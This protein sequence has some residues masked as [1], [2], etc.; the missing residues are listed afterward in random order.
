[1]KTLTHTNWV[2][3]ALFFITLPLYGCAS[4]KQNEVNPITSESAVVASPHVFE[5]DGGTKRAS[6][7][8]LMALF[9]KTAYRTDI[10]DKK[11]RR[12]TACDYLTHPEHRDVLLGM[13]RDAAGSGWA[14]WTPPGSCYGEDGLYFETYVHSNEKGDIDKAVIGIRGTENNSVYEFR[15]D[16]EANLSGMTHAEN[17]EYDLAARHI[18]PVINQLAKLRLN[19]NP[20][21]IYLTGHSLGGGIAQYIAYLAPEVTATFTFDTSPVT[22]W[23]QLP[24]DKKTRTPKIYR[25]YLDKEAL[26]IVRNFAAKFTAPP[27]NRFDYE[28]F[29]VETGIF[30][31]HDISHLAC[32][33]AARVPPSGAAYDYS[34]ASATATL[35]NPILCS[36]EV[37]KHIPSTLL[38]RNGN[39]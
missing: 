13:P 11:A 37:R 2:I 14:R 31:A 26:S 6:Q 20:I 4:F 25:A 12:Y 38:D 18:I 35:N 5:S 19:G 8:A 16:W 23:F 3:L 17:T 33:L 34:Y 27:Y 22:R 32:Q 24:E 28:F 21:E 36:D 39:K 29:F 1:M 15:H 30:D 7:F 10:L 9:A